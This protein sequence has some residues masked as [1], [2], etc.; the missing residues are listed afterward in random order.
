MNHAR[1]TFPFHKISTFLC[2]TFILKENRTFVNKQR[3]LEKNGLRVNDA[4]FALFAENQDFLAFVE[5]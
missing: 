4:A 2:I 5:L 1:S 3:V